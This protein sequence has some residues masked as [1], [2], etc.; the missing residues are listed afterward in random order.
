ML[1]WADILQFVEHGNPAPKSEITKSDVEWHTQFHK[2]RSNTERLFNSERHDLF[3]Q[4]LYACASCE[5]VLF[6]TN[7]K[8]K[9]TTGILSFSQPITESAVAYHDYDNAGSPHVDTTCNYCSAYLGKLLPDGPKP[10]GLRYCIDE[11]A[12]EKVFNHFHTS[13]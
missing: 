4:D 5:A 12:L 10:S 13:T 1:K 11:L 2:E 9:S 6:G 8:L 7:V 3:E